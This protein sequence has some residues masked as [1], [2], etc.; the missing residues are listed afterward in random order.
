MWLR[1]SNALVLGGESRS[2]SWGVYESHLRNDS[3]SPSY[4]YCWEDANEAGHMIQAFGYSFDTC[5]ERKLF[6]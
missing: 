4:L 6:S 2:R 1:E 5:L 3:G